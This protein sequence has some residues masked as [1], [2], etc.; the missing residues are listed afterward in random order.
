[1][2]DPNVATLYLNYESEQQGMVHCLIQ[3]P[4]SNL[5]AFMSAYEEGNIMIQS[6]GK[7]I[8]L[9]YGTQPSRHFLQLAISNSSRRLGPD[10]MNNLSSG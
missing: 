4:V 5:E 6:Y 3:V 7:V 2:Q 8:A 9:E 10:L 1:M